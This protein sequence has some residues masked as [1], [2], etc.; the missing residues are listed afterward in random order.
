M[1][2]Y[3]KTA[4]PTVACPR[5]GLEM[6][7]DFA[8]R[9]HDLDACRNGADMKP[10][11]AEATILFRGEAEEGNTFDW[12]ELTEGIADL[13]HLFGH[14]VPG[15]LVDLKVEAITPEDER[16][17]ECERLNKQKRRETKKVPANS[18]QK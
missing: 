5:C 1:V 2:T 6:P 15:E 16:F 8:E 4:S 13:I 18:P 3:Q 11:F 7:A 12:L 9:F 17:G 10:L 14:R